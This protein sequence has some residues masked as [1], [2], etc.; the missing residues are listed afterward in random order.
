VENQ[1]VENQLVENDLDNR[2]YAMI[3]S[4]LDRRR[5]RLSRRKQ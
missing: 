4:L 1:L 5:P 2:E 3:P